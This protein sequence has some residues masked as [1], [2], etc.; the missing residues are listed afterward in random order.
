MSTAFTNKRAGKNNGKDGRPK[1][2]PL[3]KEEK[4]AIV[5]KAAEKKVGIAKRG[6]PKGRKNTPHEPLGITPAEIVEVIERDNSLRRHAKL[7]GVALNDRA[8]L[9]GM[10]DVF[11]GGIEENYHISDKKQMPEGGGAGRSYKRTPMQMWDSIKSYFKVSVEYGQPL[12][13]TGVATFCM[14]DKAILMDR[15]QG[16][17][18]TSAYDFLQDVSKFIEM[19]NEYML[20]KKQNP[21]G[22]IFVLKNFGWKDKYEVEASGTQGA[23]TDEE[24]KVA[25]SRIA[26]FSE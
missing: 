24:R 9:Q 6:R 3:T 12:T 17:N 20:H 5:A 25:Q 21:A 2:T 7:E 13:I 22:S 16:V 15:I 14:V 10:L 4:K 8:Y 19:Y 18:K 1:S 26:N 23:L 11:V